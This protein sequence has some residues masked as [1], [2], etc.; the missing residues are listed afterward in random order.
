MAYHQYHQNVIT[1]NIHRIDSLCSSNP[2]VCDLTFSPIDLLS[3]MGRLKRL[4]LSNI[5]SE[6]LDKILRRLTPLPCLS[7]LTINCFSYIKDR[8]NIY[9]PIFRL[10]ALKYLKLSLQDSLL[11]GFSRAPNPNNNYSVIEHWIIDHSIYLDHLESLLPYVPQLR[12]LAIQSC[13]QYLRQMITQSSPLN[14][15][16]HVSVTLNHINFERFEQL[17]RNFFLKV[18]ILRISIIYNG[19][20]AYMDNKKWERLILSHLPNLKIFDIRHEDWRRQVT[21]SNEISNDNSTPLDNEINKFTSS[22]WTERHWVFA[23]QYSET[24]YRR[25]TIFYSTEPYRYRIEIIL[26]LNI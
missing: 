24:R 16:T 13:H 9:L 15:L 22:F 19:D 10:P 26:L 7:S 20:P 17:V 3:E 5:D 6:C 21:T 18:Q 2:F 14:Y 11:S 23:F 1:P 4:V 12:R 25:R 8:N